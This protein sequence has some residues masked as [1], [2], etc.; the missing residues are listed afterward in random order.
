MFCF[1]VGVFLFLVEC[2][3]LELAKFQNKTFNQ[4]HKDANSKTKHST[5]NIK[6]PTPKQ[7][8][9]PGA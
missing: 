4:E 5:R 3:I 1:G 2:F 6:T 9:Q 7:K 8:N